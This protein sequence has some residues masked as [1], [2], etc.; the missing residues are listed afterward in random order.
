MLCVMALGAVATFAAGCRRNV[1]SQ[2]PRPVYAPPR[3]VAE[4]AR[5]W[6]GRRV[7]FLDQHDARTMRLRMRRFNTRVLD[8]DLV[9]LGVVRHRAGDLLMSRRG[10]A[11]AFL[12]VPESKVELEIVSR[13]PAE[14]SRTLVVSGYEL[15][16]AVVESGEALGDADQKPQEAAG[17][18]EEVAERDPASDDAEASAEARGDEAQGAAEDGEGEASGDEVEAAQRA[19]VVP[20]EVVGYLVPHAQGGLAWR[21]LN[22]DKSPVLALTREQTRPHQEDV[23]ESWWV[24]FFAPDGVGVQQ[25]RVRSLARSGRRTVE[26]WRQDAGGQEVRVLL[27]EDR[28]LTPLAVA[29]MLI[30]RFDPLLRAGLLVTLR[31]LGEAGAEPTSER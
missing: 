26:A 20:G 25:W 31:D 23:L 13:D 12:V 7:E 11:P 30:Q 4:A 3:N 17:A 28:V 8:P 6:P 24:E 14:T 1:H 22:A 10:G 19:Q 29:P 5:S 15:R 18:S 2:R 27:V 21:V 9:P 16:R